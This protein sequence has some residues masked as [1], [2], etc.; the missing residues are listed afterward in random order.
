MLGGAAGAAQRRGDGA[1][2]VGDDER[3][4]ARLGGLQR[5]VGCCVGEQVV[6]ELDEK[7]AV[8]M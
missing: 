2:G 5:A 1:A 7:F 6:V 8:T 4:V 3:V